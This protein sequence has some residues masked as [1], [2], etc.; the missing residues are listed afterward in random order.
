MFLALGAT[1]LAIISI[2]IALIQGPVKSQAQTRVAE[3]ISTWGQIVSS[4]IN[5]Q[6]NATSIKYATESNHLIMG[7]QNDINNHLVSPSCRMSLMECLTLIISNLS[8]DGRMLL[9]PR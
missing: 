5:D 9:R 3:G 2:E 4:T 7:T 1:G 8:L 6:M